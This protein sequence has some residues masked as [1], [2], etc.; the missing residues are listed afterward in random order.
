[1]KTLAEEGPNKLS[2]SRDMVQVEDTAF[3][4][5]RGYYDNPLNLVISSATP[6]ASIIYTT[7]GTMPSGENGIS[8]DKGMPVVILIEKSTI[9]RAIAVGKGMI[10][11]DVD[12]HT[13]LFREDIL[14]QI[15]PEGFPST[16]DFEMDLRIPLDENLSKRMMSSFLEVPSVSVVMDHNDLFGPRGIYTNPLES[17]E[18]WERLASVELITPLRKKGFQINCG[19]RIQGSGSRNTSSKKNFRLKFSAKFGPKKLKAKLFTESDVSEFDSLVLRNPTHDSWLAVT[20]DWRNNARYVNDRWASETQRKMGYPSPHQRWIHLYLNGLYWGIYALSERPDESFMASYFGG[21]KSDY[22]VLNSNLLR[23]GSRDSFDQA[24]DLIRIQG[25]ETREDYL[26]LQKFIDLDA[27]IDYF[28]YRAPP[29]TY[30][31]SESQILIFQKSSKP[32]KSYLRS[33]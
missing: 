12:T 28:L 21:D 22:D 5:N 19:T 25:C 15:R 18:E 7:D 31:S 23:N 27:F 6:S 1:M 17:G 14:K 11:S 10:P 20:P 32:L 4:S 29:E 3:S 9:V 16:V 13:Y 24:R 8:G 2:L 30:F 33:F 26:E